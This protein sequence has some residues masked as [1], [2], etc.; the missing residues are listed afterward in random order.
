MKKG[1]S[2]WAFPEQP[3]AKSFKQAKSA[4]FEG[5]EVALAETGEINLQSTQTDMEQIRA[6]AVQ[7]NLSLYSVATGLYWTYSMTSDDP[8]VRKKAENIVKKQLDA[9]LWL[10][11]D[12]ILVI[13]GMVAGLE[14]GGEVVPYQT[15][16]NR[17]AEAINRLAAYAQE[18]GVI[19][20]LENVWN[21]FLLSPLEYRD[22]IGKANS[23]F[24]KA[25]FDVGNVVR[26]GYP[27]HWIDILGDRIAKVHFKDYKRDIGTLDG[28]VDLLT[29][30]VNYP[31][32]LKALSQTGYNGWVTAEVF[33]PVGIEHDAWLN[34]VSW[35]M[36]KILSRASD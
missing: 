5:V 14:P 36:D 9:A 31:A 11:C 16:Y 35:A 1:I 8:D 21:K 12:T 18:R 32:V 10:G 20:G 29:G 30:D 25:Y 4:G 26:D 13:P 33:P 24:V 7:N 34:E 17:A 19:I 27:E 15:V 28:F 3:L 23:P 6:L 2:I 22:F